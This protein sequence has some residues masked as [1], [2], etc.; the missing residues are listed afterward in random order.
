MAPESHVY[1]LVSIGNANIS[2]LLFSCFQIIKVLETEQC[3]Q[4]VGTNYLFLKLMLILS[5][6]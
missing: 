1:I 5:I 3:Y 6:H 2:N 4:S